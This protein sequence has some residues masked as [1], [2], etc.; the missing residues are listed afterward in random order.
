MS[1]K[2]WLKKPK[3]C[4]NI[5]SKKPQQPKDRETLNGLFPKTCSKWANRFLVQLKTKTTEMC[6]GQKRQL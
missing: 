3:G 6:F 5:T 2:I 1:S 4:L